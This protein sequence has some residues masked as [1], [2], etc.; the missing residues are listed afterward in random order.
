[1]EAWYC[2]TGWLPGL[3][4]LALSRT[5]PNLWLALAMALFGACQIGHWAIERAEAARC[6]KWMVPR[7][8]EVVLTF[9]A[10][11]ILS[12]I[13]LVVWAWDGFPPWQ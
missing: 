8:V 11:P 4:I 1:M 6:Q 10:F 9:V 12:T 7:Y 2:W 3:V 13:G 5:C